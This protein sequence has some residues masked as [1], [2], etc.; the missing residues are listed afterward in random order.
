MIPSNSKFNGEPDCKPSNLVG[1]SRNCQAIVRQP[2]FY[3]H[4]KLFVFTHPICPAW[5]TSV[6]R[7]SPAFESPLGTRSGA[8]AV[9]IPSWRIWTA[10][11]S[12]FGIG[13][14]RNINMKTGGNLSN[15]SKLQNLPSWFWG[16]F[17]HFSTNHKGPIITGLLWDPQTH[18][19]SARHNGRDVGALFGEPR[20][21]DGDP[22]SRPISRPEWEEPVVLCM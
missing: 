15:S 8:P 4:E 11:D 16:T 13:R 18:M 22:I 21:V 9:E 10:S 19:A 17:H 2:H 7:R 14:H 12:C 1:F 6:F 3:T 5:Q 20:D